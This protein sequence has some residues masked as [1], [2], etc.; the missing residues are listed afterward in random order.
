MRTTHRLAGLALALVAG[1]ATTACTTSVTGSA[2]PVPTSRESSP[3]RGGPTPQ[4][5]TEDTTGD[6]TEGAPEQPAGES[7]PAGTGDDAL[8]VPAPACPVTRA[9]ASTD[10]LAASEGLTGPVTDLGDVSTAA[11]VGV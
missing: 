3:D 9:R 5:T 2:T 11:G 8:P 7:V 4:E 10:V 1:T 6:D